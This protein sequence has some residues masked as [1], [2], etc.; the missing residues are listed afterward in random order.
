MRSIAIAA[1][2]AMAIVPAAAQQCGTQSA[3]FALGTN[4]NP[5]ASVQAKLRQSLEQAGFK[6]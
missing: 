1:V 2:L 3:K 5:A 6:D 4:R